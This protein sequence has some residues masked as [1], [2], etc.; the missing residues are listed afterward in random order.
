MIGNDVCLENELI[1]AECEQIFVEFCNQ[2]KCVQYLV[3][4]ISMYQRAG[5]P[6]GITVTKVAP[7]YEQCN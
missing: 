2:P 7:Q 4:W 5:L 3:N 1:N 6:Y